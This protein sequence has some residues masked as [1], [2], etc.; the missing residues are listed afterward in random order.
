MP[1]DEIGERIS[2]QERDDDD[3]ER[4]LERQKQGFPIIDLAQRLCVMREREAVL[5]PI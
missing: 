1:H 4:Q 2:D 5:A 3:E